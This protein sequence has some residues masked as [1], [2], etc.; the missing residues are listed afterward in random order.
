MA[1][2]TLNPTRNFAVARLGA[3]LAKSATTLTVSS[4]TGSKF[5]PSS[6]GQ[7]RLVI[8]D[9]GTYDDPADDP[10]VEMVNCT[11]HTS[12]ADTFTITRAQ[13][14][15][16]DVA[17]GTTSKVMRALTEKDWLDID[18]N[19]S[20]GGAV[21]SVF[22]R[23]GAV[24]AVTNDYTWAQVNKA[25]SSIA[26][27]TTKSHAILS[28]LD[29]ASASH[30]GF[31]PTVTKGNLTAGSSKISIGGTGTGAV[32]G[33]G[34]SV[35]VVEANLTLSS[36]GGAVTDAQ[37]PNTITLD[38]ITQITTRSHTSLSDI[39]TNTHATI[40]S[41]LDQSVK[42]AATPTFAGLNSTSNIVLNNTYGYK[43]KDGAGTA[44]GGIA[45]DAGN[46]LNIGDS[47][48][49]WD[50]I[51]FFPGAAEGAY[52][53]TFFGIPKP[54]ILTTSTDGLVLENTTDSTAV[55]TVQMSP[56]LRFHGEAWLTGGTPANNTSD[57]II[58]NILT[59]GNP[60]ISR[61]TISYS[62]NGGAYTKIGYF[63]YS[64]N[65]FGIGANV[66][67]AN[68]TGNNNFAFGDYVLD[69]NTTGSYNFAGLYLALSGNTTGSNNIAIGQ[70]SLT[71][72][73]SGSYNIA[74]GDTALGANTTGTHNFAVGQRALDANTI[75]TNNCAIGNDALTDN[76]TGNYN[77]AVGFNALGNN[78]TSSDNIAIGQ[79]A[80]LENTTGTWNCAF[81]W[82]TLREN[83]TGNYN[84][85][86]G[87]DA[88]RD[89]TTGSN[90]TAVGVGAGIGTITA[91]RSN[92]C[93]FGFNS[94]YNISTGS[95]NICIGYQAANN[96]TT[97]SNNLIIGYD[98]DAP[99]ATASNQLS[100][101]NIIFAT[102]VDGTGTTISTGGV[103]LGATSP[104]ATAI[105]DLTSTTKGFLAPRMTT[106][107]RN[108]ISSP[109]TGIVLYN[110]SNN[111]YEFK[112]SERWQRINTHTSRVPGLFSTEFLSTATVPSYI[113]GSSAALSSGTATYLEGSFAHP[114]QGRFAAAALTANSGWLIRMAMTGN[115]S[116]LLLGGE[117]ESTFIFSLPASNAS[118]IIMLGF[119]D[120]SGA[121]EF[122]DGVYFRIDNLTL[123]GKTSNNSTRSS[124][125][126]SI[127]LT[128]A[129]WYRATLQLNA[130]ATQVT[131]YLYDSS[132]NE[133]A[134]S[135]GTN[136]LTTNIPTT[137]STGHGMK[138]YNTDGT[139]VSA[140][141][142]IDMDYMDFNLN[143]ICR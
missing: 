112:D 65:I 9:A 76:T 79:N 61:L 37:V 22:G 134:W 64:G 2:T 133:I 42:I 117:E 142:L 138:T 36:I 67:L 136:T 74:F 39:G 108:A 63:G 40:D 77:F 41:Y 88:N 83:T 18:A 87:V 6:E 55:N 10:N 33:A 28:A 46:D 21:S 86:V 100:I 82:D 123:I 70:S 115:N 104:A 141:D 94:A 13:D 95:N 7:F 109:A 29:Y 73:T 49:G 44:R 32:I 127:T 75:G 128:T 114:G 47:S 119:G 60:I 120:Q 99:S 20:G 140:T 107:Q 58:E 103:S 81:G 143:K 35:D 78:T 125:T 15:T 30:T 50:K 135:G 124:T 51:A 129:T 12:G 69:A 137:R 27:I 26:D 93:F 23:T 4:G 56:R 45:G 48:G 90:N 19:L 96:L 121:A 72:N 11:S 132:G 126:G 89:N 130:D 38:N 122:V 71:L 16:S 85:G 34:A 17:H 131:F 68:T 101:G 92:N 1:V 105:L 5:P 31:E 102:G 14:S 59:S 111:V 91:V 66:L 25:T 118:T 54:N 62:D 110:T 84:V 53:T 24:V 113:W 106:A 57:W 116:S 43:I 52:I 3:I 97:G 139:R 98:I 80:L 8:W